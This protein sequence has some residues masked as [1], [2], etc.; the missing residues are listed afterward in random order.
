[1]R[2]PSRKAEK[3]MAQKASRTASLRTAMA[4]VARALSRTPR[5]RSTQARAM[6]ITA[7]RLTAPPSPGPADRACGSWTPRTLSSS[8]LTYWLQPT[9]TAETDTP[10]SRSRHQPTR[11]A[12]RSPSPA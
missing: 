11:K 5:T 1:M 3:P 10:Y 2:L 8:S 12:V 6:T 9:A 4:A 7:G